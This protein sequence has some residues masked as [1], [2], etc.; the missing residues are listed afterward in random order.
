MIFFYTSPDSNRDNMDD[1]PL[2][3]YTGL[4]PVLRSTAEYMASNKNPIGIKLNKRGIYL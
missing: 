2:Q 3:V 4:D 1:R